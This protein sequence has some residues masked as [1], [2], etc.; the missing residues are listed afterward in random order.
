MNENE[1]VNNTYSIEIDNSYRDYKLVTSTR[2]A[3]S[4]PDFI[5][6]I[7]VIVMNILEIIDDDSWD[8]SIDRELKNNSYYMHGFYE[9]KKGQRIGENERREGSV[10]LR[11]VLKPTI[12]SYDEA[13]RTIKIHTK[14]QN[15]TNIEN[16]DELRM[17]FTN[18]KQIVK[19]VDDLK[20]RQTLGGYK[21]ESLETELPIDKVFGKL[22][23]NLYK[24]EQVLYN[25]GISLHFDDLRFNSEGNFLAKSSNYE[26]NCYLISNNVLKNSGFSVQNLGTINV[27]K[28]YVNKSTI[29]DWDNKIEAFLETHK[30]MVLF[31]E[32]EGIKCTNTNGELIKLC[33]KI[34]TIMINKPVE[35]S[36]N[37]FLRIVDLT[38]KE[39][40]Q[41]IRLYSH[42]IE[43]VVN[44]NSISLRINCK[45]IEQNS[46]YYRFEVINGKHGSILKHDTMIDNE[47][48]YLEKYDHEG[49]QV[50]LKSSFFDTIRKSQGIIELSSAPISYCIQGFEINDSMFYYQSKPTISHYNLNGNN[51]SIKKRNMAR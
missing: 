36:D 18:G 30:D 2:R 29:L 16:V 34:D 38:N 39:N 51:Y 13:N 14:R 17:V 40:V 43:E 21:V 22:E 26:G 20:I 46:G 37:I 41:N 4:N 33:S 31:D 6:E 11:E 28:G 23:Y 8:R 42:N 49:Y 35:R 7:M 10:S 15:I 45:H 47:L 25:S 32:I 44:G 3:L 12:V 5:D 1:E 27:Y 24:K 48:K 19:Q 50:T 9:Y